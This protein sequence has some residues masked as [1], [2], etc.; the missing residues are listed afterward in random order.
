MST[1]WLLKAHLQPG[2]RPSCPERTTLA[3]I[4]KRLGR[5]LRQQ[6]GRIAKPDTILGWYRQLVAAKFDGS[7]QRRT[8]GRP[9]IDAGI[10]SL[11]VR[12]RGRIPAGATTGW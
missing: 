2:F 4:G 8:P 7:G 6:V 11:L 10:E 12:L 3:E 9:R 1:C 5:K